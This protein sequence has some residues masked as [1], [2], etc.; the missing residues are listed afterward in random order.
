MPFT[1]SHPAAVLPLVRRLPPSALV[2]GAMVPDTVFYV[3]LPVSY[4]VTHSLSGVFTVDLVIGFAL[5]ALW[6]ELFGAAVM[7]L[8]PPGVSARLRRPAPAGL[9]YHLGTPGRAARTAAGLLVGALTHV[10]WDSFTHAGAWGVRHS[11]WLSSWHGSRPGYDWA[12]DAS[13]VLGGLALLGYALW[14]WSTTPPRSRPVAAPATVRVLGCGLV[15]AATVAGAAD[16]WRLAH[17]P[18][19]MATHGITA[20]LAAL[21]LTASIH[22]GLSR[23][24]R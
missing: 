17:N 8:L 19:L 18:F 9:A 5:F 1:G 2:I 21:A 10:V 22:Y 6:Q 11:T 13:T 3:P 4:E 12:Q 15:A 16:G 14:W 24:R 20:G 7:A 23:S